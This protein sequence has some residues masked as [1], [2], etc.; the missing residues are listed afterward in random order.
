MAEMTVTQRQSAKKFVKATAQPL[1]IGKTLLI[2]KD[3][4]D[5]DV[6]QKPLSRSPPLVP[7]GNSA[8]KVPT[9]TSSRTTQ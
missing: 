2:P 4:L 9:Q 1:T 6:I 3:P 8:Q 5:A 7:I